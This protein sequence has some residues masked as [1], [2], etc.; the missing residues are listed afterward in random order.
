MTI[1][2]LVG[3]REGRKVLE[4]RSP[5]NLEV[6]GELVCAN[7]A[8]VQQAV[9]TARRAQQGW[10]ALGVAGRVA[11]MQKGA[12]GGAGRQRRDPARDHQ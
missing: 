12:G 6:Q 10:A 8:D 1:F 2:Q 11:C 7:A 9:A 4:I 3:E 5:V